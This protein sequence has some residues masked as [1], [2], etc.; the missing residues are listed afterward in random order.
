M[1]RLDAERIALWRELCTTSAR[2]QRTIDR[3]LNDLHGLPLPWFDALTEIRRAGGSVRVHE[4]CV[5]L[6][7]VPSSLSR[8][9][10]RMEHEGFVRRK[11]SPRKD[12]RR[13]V[14]VTSTPDGRAAWFDANVT[15]R[16]M[17][18]HH[19][20]QRLTDTD[21]AALQRVWG[22]LASATPEEE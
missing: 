11:A 9:L 22:K 15:Y 17:V 21:I 5:A 18:Q 7:E 8:R 3:T 19:F 10:D 4:L 6:D 20:A 2:L 14:I 12:D 16:R 13:A 1:P